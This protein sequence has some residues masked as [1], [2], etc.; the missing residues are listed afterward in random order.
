M[1]IMNL[2][3]AIETIEPSSILPPVYP[4]IDVIKG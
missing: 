4:C 1:M 3:S 2:R